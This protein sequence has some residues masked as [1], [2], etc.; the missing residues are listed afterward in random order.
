MERY[1]PGSAAR[2]GAQAGGRLRAAARRRQWRSPFARDMMRATDSGLQGS[3]MV[4]HG[5]EAGPRSRAEFRLMQE[6]LDTH[7]RSLVGGAFY[8]AGWLLV[9]GYGGAFSTAPI[10]A[11]LVVT[12]FVLL[13]LARHLV[14]P[15]TEPGLALRWLAWNRPRRVSWANVGTR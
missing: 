6:M 9:G 10:A 8:L 1:A 7:R 12:A 2:R 14:R 13:A 11:W 15:P 4:A 5:R 3:S